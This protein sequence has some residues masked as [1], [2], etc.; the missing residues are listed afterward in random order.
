[1]NDG[2]KNEKLERITIIWNT[3]L[4]MLFLALRISVNIT[5]KDSNFTL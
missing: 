2:M 3:Y 5:M 4:A 1:M